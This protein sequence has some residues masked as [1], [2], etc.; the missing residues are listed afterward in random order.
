M[1]LVW[2]TTH[3]ISMGTKYIMQMLFISKFTNRFSRLLTYM[4]FLLNTFPSQFFFKKQTSGLNGRA[5]A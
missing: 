5:L 4:S 2:K 1:S 3:A